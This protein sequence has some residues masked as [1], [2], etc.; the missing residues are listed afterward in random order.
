MPFLALLAVLLA[1]VALPAADTAIAMDFGSAEVAVRRAGKGSFIGM[2]PKGCEENFGWNASVATSAVQEEGGRCFLRFTVASVDQGVQFAIPAPG[3]R[4]GLEAPTV[5][6]L[7]LDYRSPGSDLQVGLREC[8][9]PWRT[10]WNSG[11]LPVARDWRTTAILLTV[12]RVEQEAKTPPECGLFLYLGVGCVDLGRLSLTRLDAAEVA[13]LVRRPPADARNFF[14]ASRFPLGLPCGWNLDRDSHLAT[15]ASDPARLGPSGSPALVLRGGTGTALHSA[16]FQSGDPSRDNHVAIAAAGSGTW[17]MSVLSADRVLASREFAAGEAWATQVLSFRPDALARGFALKLSGSG[18][19]AID[20][21]QAW[22]GDPVRPYAS[23]R[24]GEIALAVGPS[25]LAET[26]IQFADEPAQALYRATGPLAGARLQAQVVD[27]RGR[28]RTLPGRDLAREPGG[29]LDLAVFP[30]AP[31]GQFRVE[32]WAERDGT[33]IT[34][35]TELV[36]TRLPRPLYWGKDAPASPFGVHALPDPRA[37]RMLKAGGLNWARLHDSGRDLVGWYW[38]E[39]ERGVWTFRDEELLRYRAANLLLYGQL[40]SAPLWASYYADSGKKAAVS[41][42]SDYFDSSF[43]P[44]DLEGWSTYVTTVTRRYRGV[45]DDWFVWNEPWGHDFFHRGYDAAKNRY[46]P[47]PTAPQDFVELCRRAYAAAK[48]VDPAIRI[49]GFN[50]WADNEGGWTRPVRE[51]GALKA[52]DEI[53]YHFYTARDNAFPGD[54][55][56]QAYGRVM[57]ALQQDGKPYTG[58]VVMSEGQGACEGDR[59]NGMLNTGMYR[60]CLPWDAD[61]DGVLIADRTCRFLVSHLALRVKRVFTYTAH[62]YQDLALPSNFL[63]L[64]CADGF[65]HPALAAHAA[66]AL[67]LEDRPFAA[68]APLGDGGIAYAFAGRGRTVAVIAGRR[69]ATVRIPASPRWTVA[70]LFGNPLPAP[71]DYAGTLLYVESDLPA[72]RLLA[73][74]AGK[75]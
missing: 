40:G 18:V 14:P 27:L 62:S 6:R 42:V 12:P 73:G 36:V 5:F 33:R 41:W 60:H 57:A 24:D 66:L 72:D 56:Q 38:L 51:A 48:A 3:I 28:T 61:E 1:F 59:G 75:P 30:D 58:T 32:A 22:I 4:L 26:R 29:T 43:Q 37:L 70:D 71:A 55:V 46:L 10:F 7:E 44:K 74:L 11:E 64:V 25:E 39:R 50:T 16:P 17:T 34:A 54:P 53:D 45:I 69:S 35:V 65:P 31:F 21:L 8:P 13:A 9:A 67:R 2:L 23:G 47:S 20:A 63:A 15:V 68:S 19:L 49:S 52:C